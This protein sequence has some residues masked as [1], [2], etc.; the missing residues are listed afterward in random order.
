MDNSAGFQSVVETAEKQS[1][2]GNIY[3]EVLG[4]R[5]AQPTAIIEE[6]KPKEELPIKKSDENRKKYTYN[7]AVAKATGY[8]KGDSLAAGVWVNKYALKDSD[9]NIYELTPDDMHRRI[10]SEI[11]RDREKIPQSFVGG[12]S[13]FPAAK[14]QI[15][16]TTRQSHGRHWESISDRFVVQL[17]CNRKPQCRLLWRYHESG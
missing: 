2:E 4:K 3:Q 17:L 11:A 1:K 12:K 13:I 8:F 6:E 5:A 10:A 14:F 16:R 15:H 9:G 7:E